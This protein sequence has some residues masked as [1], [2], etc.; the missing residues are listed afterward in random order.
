MKPILHDTELNPVERVAGHG[1][2]PFLLTC[3]H[4][5]RL[6]PETCNSLGLDDE[7]TRAHIAWD[8]GAAG[9]A[10][11]LARQLGATAFLQKYSRL[12]IDCNRPPSV[13][14]SIPEISEL[15][16]I[17]GNLHLTAEQRQARQASFFT[18]YHQAIAAQLDQR[19][20]HALRTVVISVHSFTPVFKGR[21][22]DLDIGVLFN[23]DPRLGNI[24]LDLLSTEPALRVVA[25][26]PYSVSDQ[27]DYTIPVHGEARGLPHVMI[28]INNTLIEHEAEQVQWAGRFAGWLRLADQRL[29]A[30]QQPEAERQSRLSTARTTAMS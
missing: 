15:T 11:E 14:S 20:S 17:P 9:V 16:R 22:R 7:Q 24:L 18:P 23:R 10:R 25:N 29:G 8:I 1:D 5:G 26:K 2:C 21:R 4:G 30:V 12:L 27:T 28:E 3:D 19:A 13:A 6:L